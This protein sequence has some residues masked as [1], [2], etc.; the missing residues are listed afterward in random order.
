MHK[1]LL[2]M[3]VLFGA[4]SVS[5]D[6]TPVVEPVE[7][8]VEVTQVAKTDKLDQLI[9]WVGR[10]GDSFNTKYTELMEEDA[11]VSVEAETVV[12]V[13]PEVPAVKQ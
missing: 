6:E 3:L 10:I 7:P 1:Y 13:E 2:S 5:A 8:P 11:V 12:E 9:A 4:L